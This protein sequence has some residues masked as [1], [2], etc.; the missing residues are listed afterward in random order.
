MRNGGAAIWARKRLEQ[1]D[2]EVHEGEENVTV[3]F[4][5]LVVAQRRQ[6]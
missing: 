4:G 3:Q 2:H 1:L 6:Q 5:W